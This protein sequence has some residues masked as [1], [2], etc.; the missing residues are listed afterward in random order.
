MK[1]L[2]AS[3][4]LA[5]LLTSAAMADVH[6]G[7]EGDANLNIGNARNKDGD[8]TSIQ[9]TVGRDWR[10]S[11]GIRTKLITNASNEYVG[12]EFIF[13]RDSSIGG[14]TNF[15]PAKDDEKD[16]EKVTGVRHEGGD[17]AW[18]D[19]AKIW[20]TPIK[21]FK[22]WVGQGTH[23]D[24]RGNA[25]YGAN[26]FCTPLNAGEYKDGWTFI[27]QGVRGVSVGVFPIEGLSLYGSWEIPMGRE[28]EYRY[29]WDNG[30]NTFRSEPQNIFGRQA[31]Y[32][33]AYEIN[34]IGA[35][36]VGIDECVP[37]AHDKDGHF[38]SQNVISASFELKAVENLYAAIGAFIPTVQ[39][40]CDS[41]GKTTG[42]FKAGEWYGYN[43]NAFNRI[44]AYARYTISDGF[45]IHAKVGTILNSPDIK[46]NNG[47]WSEK[48]G[49]LGF[50]VG[51]G[52]DYPIMDTVN[53]NLNTSYANG[54]YIW[55]SSADHMDCFDF[56]VT[57]AKEF[58]NCCVSAGV[59]GS[60]TN[61]DTHAMYDPS[62]QKSNGETEYPF[63]WGVPLHIA[64]WF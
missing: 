52:L 1:K 17:L 24:I 61:K 34:G 27:G 56:A 14:D 41:D 63:S 6:I 28:R 9:A 49:Q 11:N 48:D 42:S 22:L 53:L 43:R 62:Y 29:D 47:T 19:G 10:D 44:N 4:A 21:Q 60:T 64:F 51:A 39:Y 16:K 20:W 58:P 57:I 35:V 55:G 5:T 37:N 18:I 26:G 30:D 54:I 2:A 40:S 46:D 45:N 33:A 31:K 38:K 25:G 15:V 7:L 50:Y 13:C 36:K 8:G 32:C 3:I 59:V 12:G 23:D